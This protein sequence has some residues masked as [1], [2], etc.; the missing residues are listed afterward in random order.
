MQNTVVQMTWKSQPQFKTG[1]STT[2]CIYCKLKPNT[3]GA[4][5]G[6]D[7]KR[8]VTIWQMAATSFFLDTGG[9]R[10]HWNIS[11]KVI[12]EFIL[13]RKAFFHCF[14]ARVVSGFFSQQ[15]GFWGQ[16]KKPCMWKSNEKRL[17]MLAWFQLYGLN[18]Y[19]T[20]TTTSTPKI[21]FVKGFMIINYLP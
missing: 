12:A 8:P 3:W 1:Q 13:K 16:K 4:S 21:S 5:W 6:E 18:Y 15:F 14:L 7:I 9:S 2:N 17:T 10:F 19:A 11:S 20:T